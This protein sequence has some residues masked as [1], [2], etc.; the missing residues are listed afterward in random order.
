M[1]KI[2]L[3]A[4]VLVLFLFSCSKDNQYA[5]RITGEWTVDKAEKY[6]F[7]TSTGQWVLD[8]NASINNPGTIILTNDNKNKEKTSSF[9]YTNPATV[10][11]NHNF[12]Y[13][14]YSGDFYWSVDLGNDNDLKMITF[15][16]EDPNTSLYIYTSFSIVENSKKSLTWYYFADTNEGMD[17]GTQYKWVLSLSK[18]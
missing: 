7:N 13:N 15:M 10:E 6:N 5:R 17:N 4:T 9:P 2:L 12:I 3:I 11:F 16:F 18:L 1:K 14:F 8:A